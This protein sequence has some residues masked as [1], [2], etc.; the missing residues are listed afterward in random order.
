M[1]INTS[2]IIPQTGQALVILIPGLREVVG[3]RRL[4]TAR[5]AT[6][7]SNRLLKLRVTG[8]IQNPSV[9]IDP[10]ISVPETAVG[11]FG[12]VLKLPLELL[13]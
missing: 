5:I 8:T 12:Q 11:F 4:A 1:L 13:R 2:Q 3:L 10:T 9:A 6:F 7:L